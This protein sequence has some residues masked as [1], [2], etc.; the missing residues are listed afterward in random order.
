MA[1]IK[2]KY[3]IYVGNSFRPVNVFSNKKRAI[4]YFNSINAKYKALV[5][6]IYEEIK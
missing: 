4:K 6:I 5:K 3:I 2:K 1:S